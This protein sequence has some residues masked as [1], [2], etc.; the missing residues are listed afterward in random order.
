MAHQS[1]IFSLTAYTSVGDWLDHHAS[2]FFQTR[3]AL[4]WFIRHHR[5]EL[6]ERDALIPR[7]GRNGSLIST[8]I[9]PKA[10]LDILKREALARIRV[11]AIQ[12]PT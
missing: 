6:V 7:A 5:E 1:D 12:K 3:S 10:V 8:E 9:F 11:C 4:D 2:P